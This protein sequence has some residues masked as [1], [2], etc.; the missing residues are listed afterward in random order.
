MGVENGSRAMVRDALNIFILVV[1]VVS[2][3]VLTI[4]GSN[5][6]FFLV[7]RSDSLEIVSLLLALCVVLPLSVAVFYWV[8]ARANAMLGRF[9]AALLVGVCISLFAAPLVKGFDALSGWQSLN[10]IVFSGS[11]GA[12][13][14]ACWPL[15]RLY[16]TYMLPAVFIV[17][18]FFWFN[19]DL[20]K[21]LDVS[22]PGATAHEVGKP[23]NVVMVVLDSFPLTSLLTTTR[24]VDAQRFPNFAAL[25]ESATWY[26][27]ASS[28][29][30]LTWWAVPSLLT[31]RELYGDVPLPMY[32]V[33]PRNLFTAFGNAYDFHVTEYISNFCPQ[34][35]CRV[36]DISD[37][38][39]T[40]K[41]KGLLQDGLI[42]YQHSI[43]PAEF[44][45]SLPRIGETLGGFVNGNVSRDT[46]AEE[47]RESPGAIMGRFI[48]SLAP[49]A[50]PQFFFIHALLPHAPWR[51]T[52]SGK[53]YGAGYFSQIHGLHG[54]EKRWRDDE[55]AVKLAY[56]R[57]LLQVGYVDW[58]VGQLVA[59]LKAQSL[60][61][62]TMLIVVSDHGNSYR[63]GHYHRR[64]TDET[65]HDLLGV[66]LFI[67]YPGQKEGATD[68]RNVNL[69]DV[70]P[71]LFD[72]LNVES[73]W[74]LDGTSLLSDAFP[75][76]EGKRMRDQK[77]RVFE[78]ATDYYKASTVVADK[79]ALLATGEGLE[80]LFAISLIPELNGVAVS[81][82]ESRASTDVFTLYQPEQFLDVDLSADTV[83]VFVS[84]RAR[85][86]PVNTAVAIA[87]NDEIVTVTK[88]FSDAPAKRRFA[89]M[90]P[91]SRIREGRN[92]LSIFRVE[93]EEGEWILYR[94]AVEAIEK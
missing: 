27:N 17:P 35:I 71:T 44:A 72:Q 67:K 81:A 88:V 19:P 92:S 50:R 34:D 39:R 70:L 25:A 80:D 5:T 47:D 74:P 57:H 29:N 30:G 56:Q 51:Y 91:E 2:Q 31:G 69:V 66:P 62:D 15:L 60:Y 49:A 58:Q 4:L 21:T 86:L 84:G 54:F 23:H 76:R 3:P 28:I 78:A 13:L 53:S 59:R 63:T 68:D 73:D 40:T 94:S 37:A 42:L 77:Q 45:E 11:L 82:L 6:L 46:T 64:V 41:F 9:T 14:Y 22:D 48:Q 65:L 52:P 89:A 32:S 43:Y 36:A 33:Y 16:I 24:E 61:D 18:L 55:W 1:L 8:L 20:Q 87:L 93:Q 7:R 90:L 12:L 38:Q 10:I 26:R 79:Y 75:R 83:P 85:N